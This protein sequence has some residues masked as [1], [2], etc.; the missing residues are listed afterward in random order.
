MDAA[1]AGYTAQVQKDVSNGAFHVTKFS[2]SANIG[3]IID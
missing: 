1:G 2:P 3:P